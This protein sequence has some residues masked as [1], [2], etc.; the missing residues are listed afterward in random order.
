MRPDDDG[1]QQLGL[2]EAAWDQAREHWHDNM[3]CQFDTQHWTPLV[4]QTGR[5]LEA[6]RGLLDVLDAAQREIEY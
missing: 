4:L 3:T 6:L 1:G 5:Y 2:L